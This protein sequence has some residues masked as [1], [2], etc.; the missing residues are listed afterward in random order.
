MLEFCRLTA[1]HWV[2]WDVPRCSPSA[3]WESLLHNSSLLANVSSQ[4]SPHWKRGVRV[5]P[6]S[7]ETDGVLSCDGVLE[8]HGG[9]DEMTNPGLYGLDLQLPHRSILTHRLVPSFRFHCKRKDT[10]GSSLVLSWQRKGRL[11]LGTECAQACR[12][13]SLNSVG[14]GHSWL[15]LLGR[16]GVM[17]QSEKEL[18]LGPAWSTKT[19]LEE[20]GKVRVKTKIFFTLTFLFGLV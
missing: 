13:M 2:A 4:K 19:S 10:F 14:P 12:H 15:W 6:W 18:A 3:G 17:E 5:R 7:V 16:H 20:R 11:L 1:F 8:G 9:W